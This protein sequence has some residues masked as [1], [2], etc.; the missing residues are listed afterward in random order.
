M[1]RCF[2]LG[3]LKTGFY[4]KGLIIHALGYRKRNN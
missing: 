4:E 2:S 3:K 1:R